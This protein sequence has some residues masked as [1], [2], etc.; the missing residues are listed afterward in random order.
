[1]TEPTFTRHE[2]ALEQAAILIRDH[3]KSRKTCEGCQFNVPECCGCDLMD[4]EP[5]GWKLKGDGV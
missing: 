5:S 3:C 4:T 1:M 2:D